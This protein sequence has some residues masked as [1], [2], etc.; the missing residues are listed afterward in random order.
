MRGA[1]NNALFKVIK[2]S[3]REM[4]KAI[5]VY[6]YRSIISSITAI[7]SCAGMAEACESWRKW[8][9]F[10]DVCGDV[11]DGKYGSTLKHLGFL[12]S[13]THSVCF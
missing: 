11:Y 6:C 5:K 3:C 2:T 4:H 8:Q 13:H 1:C 7:V 12:M 10:Q 9:V